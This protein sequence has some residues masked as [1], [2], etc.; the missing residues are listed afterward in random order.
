[1]ALIPSITS[2]IILLMVS[3]SIALSTGALDPATV[4]GVVTSGQ[5]VDTSLHPQWAGVMHPDDCAKARAL[6]GGRV[7]FYNPHWLMVFWSRRWTVQ[8]KG[9]YAFELP[10]GFR[11]SAYS[12]YLLPTPFNH[13]N[14]QVIAGPSIHLSR[15][16]LI[17]E[18]SDLLN[19]TGEME[20]IMVMVA[21]MLTHH[22]PQLTS[23]LT[24]PL[25]LPFHPPPL[26]KMYLLAPS[27]L[28]CLFALFLIGAVA[29]ARKHFTNDRCFNSEGL[30]DTM[31]IRALAKDFY[32]PPH[33]LYKLR[34]WSYQKFDHGSMRVCVQN[35]Y[36][37]LGTHITAA[38]MG[39][40][41]MAIYRCCD[42][43]D[44]L[45]GGGYHQA[46][47]TN[48]LFLDVETKH[49]G[50]DWLALSLA[51][52]PSFLSIQIKTRPPSFQPPNPSSPLL[53]SSIHSAANVAGS[54]SKEHRTLSL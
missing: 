45:C 25:Y 42:P 18:T 29:P 44:E 8:P 38:R 50:E 10:F 14:L 30:I 13:P 36:W 39:D 16:H 11:Y 52:P 53:S 21:S 20:L 32:A 26:N 33:Q 4:S 3:A 43:A 34:P 31:D 37:T 28:L 51:G 17:D 9:G 54:L 24:A 12:I 27:T 47:G 46:R 49:N 2:L 6:F 22:P 40:A 1:M 5:R 48:G 7:A 35:K 19:N 23:I 15:A 41:L